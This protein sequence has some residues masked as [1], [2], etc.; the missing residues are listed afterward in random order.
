M[1]TKYDLISEMRTQGEEQLK[2]LEAQKKDLEI[3]LSAFK[4]QVGF[5]KL[6]YESKR[7]QLT[8]NDCASHLESQEQ[9]IRQF[10]QT[11]YT[12]RSF[13]TQK[14]AESNFNGEM[15]NCLDMATQINK[16]LQEQTF[17]PVPC[18]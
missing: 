11:L 4:Q 17:R 9:K 18:A 13:I 14:N 1:E 12:L 16:L 7:Q 3:R 2:Q 5:L 10:G 6:R 15:A 8:D